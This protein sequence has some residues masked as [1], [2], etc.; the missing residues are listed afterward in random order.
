MASLS[1]NEIARLIS[2]YPRKEN[3]LPRSVA[4]LA[5]LGF[6]SMIKQ[7]DE[8]LLFSS[9]HLRFLGTGVLQNSMDLNSVGSFMTTFQTLVT[10]LIAKR[11]GV[12]PKTKSVESVSKL[13]LNASPLMGSVVLR[14]RP[15]S[16][17]LGEAQQPGLAG[18]DSQVDGA[19]LE[20]MDLFSLVKNLDT[21]MANLTSR[22]SELGSQTCSSLRKLTNILASEQI[23]FEIGWRR[24]HFGAEE[25]NLLVRDAIVIHDLVKRRNLDEEEVPLT[26]IVNTASSRKNVILAITLAHG[27]DIDLYADK[28]HPVS[29]IGVAV[30]DEVSV[31]ALK[32]ERGVG[33]DLDS[34]RYKLLALERE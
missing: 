30:G 8:D 7:E 29:L 2:N 26:G 18:I 24:P 5:Q 10:R 11:T 27:E 23:D 9:G 13:A 32:T 6:E 31:R 25:A 19:F 4:D 12:D 28:D 33:E 17:V 34:V 3:L 14:I 22:L 16:S 15:A 1:E 21:D 20:L